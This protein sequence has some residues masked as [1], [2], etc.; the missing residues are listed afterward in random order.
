MNPFNL[1]FG[2][3]ESTIDTIH[4]FFSDVYYIL[5]YSFTD[6]HFSLRAIFTKKPDS[7]EMSD[8][9]IN[10]DEKHVVVVRHGYNLYQCLGGNE[11]I[12]HSFNELTFLI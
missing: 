9:M 6:K 10:D 5:D 8:I 7:L 11:N 3:K 4:N 1:R 2:E 12:F